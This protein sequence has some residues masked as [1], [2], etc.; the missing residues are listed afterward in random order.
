MA[1]LLETVTQSLLS[2][3]LDIPVIR[4][5]QDGPRPTLPY[6]SYQINSR[7]T[8]GSDHYGRVDGLGLMPI[9]GT[10]EG[11]ILV[12]IFGENAREY[13]DNLVNTMRRV[14]SHYLM[15]RLNLIISQTSTVRDLTALRD[16]A[17][18]ESMAN[19]DLTYRYT[20][21]YSDDVGVIETVSASGKLDNDK[22]NYTLKGQ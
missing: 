3:L 11:T 12:N 13:A 5:Q 4:S 16:S 21:R 2:Q 8:V 14:T 9:K 18:F 15:R 17:R 19:V 1:D 20:A 22:T 6:A 7:V 10:R